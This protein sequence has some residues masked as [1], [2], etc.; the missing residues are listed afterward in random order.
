MRTRS[1]IVGFIVLSFVLFLTAAP[2]RP[3]MPALSQPALSPDGSEIAFVAGGDIWAVSSSGGQAHLLVSHPATDDRPLYSPDGKYL[4]FTSTRTGNGDIY[5]LSLATGELRRLTW[6]DGTEAL[7]AWS[8]D[9]RWIYFSSTAHDISGMN[10]IFR[11]SADGGTPMEVTA[12]RY[13][14]EFSAAPAPAGRSEEHTS[15]LQSH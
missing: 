2:Q 13:T 10:D 3:A 7:D 6:D 4:A 11:V 9:S 1:L 12:D 8:R 5:V 15:E 14:T